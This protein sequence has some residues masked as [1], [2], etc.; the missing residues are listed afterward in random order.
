MFYERFSHFSPSLTSE[1]KL[2][3]YLQNF[4]VSAVVS[5]VLIFIYPVFGTSETTKK[6]ENRVQMMNEN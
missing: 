5:L 2:D 3:V 4:I 6:R 1:C